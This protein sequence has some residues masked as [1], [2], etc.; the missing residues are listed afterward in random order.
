MTPTPL[1]DALIAQH[2][3]RE[4]TKLETLEAM[5]AHARWLERRSAAWAKCARCWRDE[6]V[7]LQADLAR[8]EFER[9]DIRSNAELYKSESEILTA[10]N[11]TL[12][13]ALARVTEERN[14]Y[15]HLANVGDNS[16]Q[17]FRIELAKVTAERDHA[18]GLNPGGYEYFAKQAAACEARSFNAT[19]IAREAQQRADIACDA[20]RSAR[21]II[22]H[23]DAGLTALRAALA[24]EKETSGR[25]M[26]R[27][28]DAELQLAAMR[29]RNA[30]LAEQAKEILESARYAW[31][32]MLDPDYLKQRIAELEAAM[33]R[34]LNLITEDGD[35]SGMEEFMGTV[36]E[37][38]NALAL[39]ESPTPDHI[40]GVDNMVQPAP[41]PDT[42]RLPW[43]EGPSRGGGGTPAHPAGCGTGGPQ[44]SAREVPP[45]CIEVPGIVLELPG[46]RQWITQA[47]QITNEWRQ[48]GVWATDAEAQ[49]VLD[50]IDPDGQREERP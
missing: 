46:S 16:V 33:K 35:S 27:A 37:I 21:E 47:G 42:V 11:T 14:A 39:A 5:E 8:V 15:E 7:L 45:G 31:G 34:A 23:K 20:E 19:T 3:E 12:R 32:A 29:A 44:M 30:E 24:V 10:E 1:T 49:A 9:E 13:A 22:A 40:V 43:N 6:A 25:F 28:G 17:E 4:S 18:A 38:R 2:R 41:H 26:V 36:D 50:R 48:R